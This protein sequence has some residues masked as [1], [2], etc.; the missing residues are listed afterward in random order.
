MKQY[1]RKSCLKSAI[2]DAKQRFTAISH[3][4]QKRHRARTEQY[5][6]NGM[7]NT[8]PGRVGNAPTSETTITRKKQ[9]S[10]TNRKHIDS[11]TT[12][13]EHHDSRK[14]GQYIKMQQQQSATAYAST[15]RSKRQI[16]SGTTNPTQ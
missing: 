5:K 12:Y 13:G 7:L 4:H 15:T 2:E 1:D 16:A 3:R 11:G 10:Q 14:L 8:Q 9:N 6:I